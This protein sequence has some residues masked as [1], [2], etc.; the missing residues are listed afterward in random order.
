ME[1]HLATSRLAISPVTVAEMRSGALRARW[2]AARLSSLEEH[3]RAYSVLPIDSAVAEEWARLLVRCL[4]LGRPKGENDL[5]V[6]ATAKRHEIPL[7]T[8]DPGQQDIPG[9]TVIREDG[10][11]AT[12]PA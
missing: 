10:T 8:L 4:E 2:G 11:E 5:W 12:T 9:L 1:Q 6:A 3:L 7:A